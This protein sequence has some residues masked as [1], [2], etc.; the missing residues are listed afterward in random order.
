MNW[1][2]LGNEQRNFFWE[3]AGYCRD[4]NGIVWKFMVCDSKPIA[5]L[6]SFQFNNDDNT[7]NNLRLQIEE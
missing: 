5:N 1:L 7:E 3:Y 6:V 2:K 4:Y